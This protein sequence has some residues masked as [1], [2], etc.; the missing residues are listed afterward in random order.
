MTI[1]SIIEHFPYMGLFLLLILGGIGLPF[2]EDTTLILCGFLISTDVVKPIPAL[3]AVYSGLL[4]T[5][6]G[7]Y[8]VGK[9]YGRKIVTHKRFQKIVSPER[10]AALEDKFNK[11]GI[12]VILIGRHLVGLRAQIFL[13][14]GV[15]RMSALKFI[16]A[17]AVSSIFTIALMVGAGYMGGNSLQVIKR[18][19]TRIE[20]IGILLAVIILAVYLLFRYFKPMR[21]KTLL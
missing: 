16:M 12:L 5:D 19:I 17:D 6:F 9:K 4:I 3:L 2:P 14:A 10:L 18:D 21:S 1:S 13:A 15:M 11:K 8:V 20:H 7:L